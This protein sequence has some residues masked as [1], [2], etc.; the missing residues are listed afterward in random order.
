MLEWRRREEHFTPNGSEIRR[1]IYV[2]PYWAR[3]IVVSALMGW[4][5]DEA[6]G[7]TRT[8]P[9]S[10]PVYPYHYCV[11]VSDEQLSPDA[12]SGSPGT[13]FDLHCKDDV[14]EA[15]N[16]LAT[17]EYPVGPRNDVG[18]MSATDR[19]RESVRNA[20]LECGCIITATYRPLLNCFPYPT[21][22]S[23]PDD[24][25][26]PEQFDYVNPVFQPYSETQDIS[27]ELKLNLESAWPW[28]TGSKIGA[29]V[30][31][32]LLSFSITRL[33][34]PNPPYETISKLQNTINTGKY[35]PIVFGGV[36]DGRFVRLPEFPEECLKFDSA[37]IEKRCVP[38]IRR[39]G[40]GS[41]LTDGGGYPITRDNQWYDITL[42]FTYN[43]TYSKIVNAQGVS[44]K[45]YVGWNRRFCQPSWWNVAWDAGWYKVG[46]LD[47]LKVFP[48]LN[49]LRKQFHGNIDVIP[50]PFTGRGQPFDDLFT[51]GAP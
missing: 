32:N 2:E 16:A 29:F 44:E 9:L 14:K 15:R 37:D 1:E 30:T 46:F 7:K 34:V 13:G 20:N 51:L 21:D 41:M 42:H 12:I 50:K 31:R 17:K 26:V 36:A 10:D 5:D 6:G 48:T 39:R 11:D 19:T 27:T 49:D 18:S 45:A 33:M 47:K 25:T 35:K 22:T 23:Q 8:L 40:D 4:V 28:P 43:T 24:P 3:P 38:T